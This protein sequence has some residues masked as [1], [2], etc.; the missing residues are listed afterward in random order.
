MAD[1][2]RALAALKVARVAELTQ[3]GRIGGDG[4]LDRLIDALAPDVAWSAC[5]P[6][7]A[8]TGREAVRTQFWSPLLKG[9]PDLELRPDLIMAGVW[10]SRLWTAHMGHLLGVFEQDVFDVPATRRPIWLRYGAFE[11]HGPGGIDE[12]YWILDLPGLMM[13]AGVWPLAPGLGA[14]LLSPA[15]ATQDGLHPT[16]GAAAEGQASLAL[17]E[18]MIAGLMR[19]DGVSLASMGMRGFWTERF[20]WYGPAGIGTMRGHQD[21]ERGHQGPFLAAFPDR[22]GGD[23]KCRIGEGPYVGSTG[24]PS[25]RATHSGGGFM[26]LAPTGRAVTMRV[27][28][29]WRRQ[30]DRLAENWVF[31][32]LIDLLN[33][34]GLDVFARMRA[35]NP[36]L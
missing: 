6:I 22:K 29:F 23:H 9:M 21:Y 5:A 28:D 1:D 19:Y 34:M 15:P 33:Q 25:I 27:M 36:R 11:R 7:N 20:G 12:T 13:Q 30:D 4:T 14:S 10:R 8:L 3:T 18:A 2:P 24:W 26:G 16:L 31:I 17:V 32:D 35:L